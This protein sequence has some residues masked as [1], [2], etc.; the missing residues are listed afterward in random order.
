MSGF[1]H[2][3]FVALH[4]TQQVDELLL[5][6]GQKAVVFSHSRPM[7]R[8]DDERVLGAAALTLRQVAQA[9]G[10]GQS[11]R[12]GASGADDFRRPYGIAVRQGLVL[13][14]GAS[15]AFGFECGLVAFA[16]Q[17]AQQTW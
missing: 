1:A 9:F 2:K 12:A 3:R 4:L 16:A 7:S 14:G 6:F 17:N 15:V 11:S 10:V 8:G 13:G 5:A